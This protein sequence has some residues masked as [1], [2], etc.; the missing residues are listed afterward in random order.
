[1]IITEGTISPKVANFGGFETVNYN[2]TVN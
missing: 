1:M 2:S